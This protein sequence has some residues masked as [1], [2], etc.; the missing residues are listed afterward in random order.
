MWSM[1]PCRKGKSQKAF[2][3]DK[4]HVH[5]DNTKG[6]RFDANEQGHRFELQIDLHDKNKVAKRYLVNVAEVVGDQSPSRCW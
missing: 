2:V 5:A 6:N 3:K 1:T 4:T